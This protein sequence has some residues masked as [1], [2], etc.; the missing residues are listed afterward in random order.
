MK[1]LLD[2]T[3]Q[4]KSLNLLFLI[5]GCIL[6][7]YLVPYVYE[8]YSY[9]DYLWVHTLLELTAVLVAFSVGTLVWLIK[10]G[11]EECRG[12]FILI[13]GLTFFAVSIID[14]MHVMSAAGMPSFITPNTEQKA[15]V[16]FI[17]GRIL[18]A[19]GVITAVLWPQKWISNT[20]RDAKV[21]IAIL[22][23]SV[24]STLL[25][26]TEYL[27]WI[28]VL[29]NKGEGFSQL[30]IQT[31]Y[32]ILTLYCFGTLLLWCVRV[33][34]GESVFNKLCYFLA[35]SAFSD[36]SFTQYEDFSDT[37]NLL[38]YI[39][40]VAA[41]YF[42][43]KAVYLSGIVNYFYTMGEMGK[44]SAELL[45]DHISVEAVLEIQ[46]PKFKKML[47]QAE[48]TV[49][50]FPCGPACFHT[51]FSE[52]RFSELF[53][54]DKE[55]IVNEAIL[56]LGDK[57]QIIQHPESLLDNNRE[58]ID[59]S[60]SVILKASRRMLYIPLTSKGIIYGHI[61]VFTF[62][63]SHCFSLEDI[64]KVRVF[65]Q[66]GTLA[67]AQAQ[68]Q[69][70][71]TQLSYE[72]SLTGLPNR[73]FFFEE[74]S[75]IKYDADKYSIPFTVVYIDMNNLKYL[76]DN[77]GHEAGDAA[78]RMLSQTIR[79]VLRQSDVP[80]RLGGDEFAI[81]F[82]HMNMAEGTQKIKELKDVF[83]NMVLEELGHTF[84]AAVGGASCP[85]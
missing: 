61:F 30:K 72:D 13:S 81:L 29:F 85:E 21:I 33:K 56:K 58:D 22:A 41:Y 32:L 48:Q 35:F 64:E 4:N 31:E 74:L 51:V 23:V 82:R 20:K 63:P 60:I 65:Q 68:T 67:I 66:F 46:M 24:I 44:M 75:K 16:F 14:L 5:A 57:I 8:V 76:N 34:I 62:R 69:A 47:P 2:Y 80:A 79:S 43:F 19:L 12:K 59:T 53:A 38:G 42:L 77:V 39:Y 83:S 28:P 54:V 70:T 26:A 7:N 15:A 52:G 17:A 27:S 6:I 45:K 55:F 40:K 1:L 11:L 37:Y 3:F 84:S 18:V 71:I 9:S 49:V 78:L 36:V 10:D 25:L 50:C 73:R